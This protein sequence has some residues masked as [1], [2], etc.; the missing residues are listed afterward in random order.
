MANTKAALIVI[1]KSSLTWFLSDLAVRAAAA[2]GF[3]VMSWQTT[4]QPVLLLGEC[5]PGILHSLE[6]VLR[7][8]ILRIIGQLTAVAGILSIL[9]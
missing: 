7:R 1:V 5:E 4:I 6:T 3:L 8:Q 9:F 2:A